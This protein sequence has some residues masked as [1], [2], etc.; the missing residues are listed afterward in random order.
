MILPAGQ[1]QIVPMEIRGR[2]GD[3]VNITC[4]VG[5]VEPSSTLLQTTMNQQLPTVFTDIQSDRVVFGYGPLT[6]ED[7]D[8]QVF[9]IFG[10]NEA[11]GTIS[12][13]CE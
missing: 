6:A 10:L 1:V 5:T 8:Q 11:E 3:I 7:H 12:V 2:V 13:L 4:I 9:C